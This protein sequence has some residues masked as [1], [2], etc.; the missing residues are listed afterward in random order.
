MQFEIVVTDN[1]PPSERQSILD[2]LNAYNE[3]HGGPSR[4]RTLAVLLRD[5]KNGET[6]GGLWAVSAY[7]WLRIDL[8]FVPEEL[9]GEG[10]G[11]RLVCQAEAIA[12][13]RAHLGVWLDTFEFQAFGFYQKLGYEVFGIMPDH[14]C[15]R[16][17]F[18]LHKRFQ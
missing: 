11:S 18:F 16:P 13:E 15:G 1:P 10:L 2:P 14:P 7:D 6:I 8:L 12:L 5:P 3:M 9:R 17:H 4:Y